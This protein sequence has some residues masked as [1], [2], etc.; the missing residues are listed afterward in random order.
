VI[1]VYTS[2]RSRR[3]YKPTLSKEG[4]LEVLME[5]AGRELDPYLAEEFVVWLPHISK[6]GKMDSPVR[7]DSSAYGFYD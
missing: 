1:D 2:L 3:T 4:A 6:M 5:M 7:P